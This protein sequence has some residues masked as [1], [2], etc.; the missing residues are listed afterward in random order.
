MTTMMSN[1]WGSNWGDGD[2]QGVVAMEVLRRGSILE[3]F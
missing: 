2:R 1:L 3:S